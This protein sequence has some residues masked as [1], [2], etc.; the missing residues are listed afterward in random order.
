ME[1][2]PLKL[3]DAF[4]LKPNIF[5]DDRG[6]FYES[7]NDNTFQNQINSHL[8]FIQDNVSRSS[9]GVLR[10]LH[11]QKEFPQGKLIRVQEGKIFDVIVDLRPSSSTF[12]GWQGIYLS[13]EEFEQIWIPPGFAHGFLVLSEF[14]EIQ[15]K[16]TAK[17][18]P[19]NELCLLWNDPELSIEWPIDYLDNEE[20]ILSQKDS[21][22]KSLKELKSYL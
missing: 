17:Y 18:S 8:K 3:N 5:F 9:K 2:K 1:V 11:F 14:A 13:S 15:Y 20:I 19:E 6:Y 10:G 4:I 7:Y 16:C 12:K 22:G 21:K